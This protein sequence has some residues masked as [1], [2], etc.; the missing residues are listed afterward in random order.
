MTPTTNHADVLIVGGGLAGLVAAKTLQEQGKSV[1]VLD[2]GRS[3]GGRLAT[4]RIGAGLADHGAQFF[5]VRTPEFQHLVDQWIIAKLVYMWSMGWSDGSLEGVTYDGHPRYASYGGM[6]A[7]AKEIEKSLK[8]VRVDVLVKAVRAI[9]TGWQVEDQAGNTYTGHALILTPPAPQS[10]ALV[11][12]GSVRLSDQ[13]QAALEAIQYAPCLTGIFLMENDTPL[14]APG[15]VQRRSAPISWIA[16]NKQKG[17][18]DGA[19]VITVQADGSY[20]AQLWNDPDPRILNALRTDLLVWLPENHTIVEEQLKR[21]RYAQPT[22]LHPEPY[23][24]AAGLP[25]LV[26]AGDGFGSARVEGA[27][28]SGLAAAAALKDL[29]P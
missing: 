17:I 11:A 4:R 18:S 13:D 25:P 29:Q 3:V 22:V 5:T 1:I 19:T 27:A 26:F 16:N 6:N 2:K 10:L 12:A 21:W 9:G 20:S 8:D 28:L 15:A 24:L 23:L 14:P 7:I